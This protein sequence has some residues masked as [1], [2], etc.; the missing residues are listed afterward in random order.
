M[1]K[2]ALGLALPERWAKLLAGLTTVLAL[3]GYFILQLRNAWRT[4]GEVVRLGFNT[5]LFLLLVCM[6]WFQPW[7]LLWIVPLAAVYPGPTPH[8]RLACLPCAPS[9]AM[10]CLALSCTGTRRQ[11]SS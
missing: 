9:G 4:P 3:G 2:L 10:W 8:S 1:I 6:S 11:R 5:L 7:Y